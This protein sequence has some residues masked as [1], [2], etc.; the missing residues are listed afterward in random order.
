MIKIDVPDALS[1]QTVN[2]V[3]LPFDWRN[4]VAP[5][6][7]KEIGTNWV[8]SNATAILSVPS[9]VMPHERNYLLNPAHPD[10]S[11]IGFGAPEPFTFDPR[12]K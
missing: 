10:F 7:T 11:K 9:A 4:P 6:A 3:A 1:I 2:D 12:L 8:R 5:D